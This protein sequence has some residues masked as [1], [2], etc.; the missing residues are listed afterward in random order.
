MKGKKRT[1]GTVP[2][3][4]RT[5]IGRSNKMKGKSKK[6]HTVEIVLKYNRTIIRF[7]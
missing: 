1:V 7:F 4:N 5:N 2:K 6:K 3:C